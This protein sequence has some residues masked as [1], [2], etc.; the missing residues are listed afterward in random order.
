MP[1]HRHGEIITLLLLIEYEPKK[2]ASTSKFMELRSFRAL[3]LKS[4]GA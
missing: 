4:F 3:E 2:I 1:A